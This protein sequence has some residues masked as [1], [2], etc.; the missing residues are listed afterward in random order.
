MAV[1][2]EHIRLSSNDLEEM[3]SLERK[4]DTYLVSRVTPGTNLY[5][6]KSSLG[7]NANV[8]DRVIENYRR[9]G[10]T[11]TERRAAKPVLVFSYANENR[12]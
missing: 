1:S 7:P 6:Y 12:D 3:T 5:F 8:V 11:V 10:W 9:S 4:I 2:P